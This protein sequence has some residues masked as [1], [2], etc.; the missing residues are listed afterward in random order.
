M[1]GKS[2][3]I[4]KVIPG[5]YAWVTL[6]LCIVLYD[7]VAVT[8]K[9]AET[10]SGAI[11]RSLAHPYKFPVAGVVWGA[12]SWHLFFNPQA[13]AAYKAVWSTHMKDYR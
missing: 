13:R 6:A 3:E 1:S 2:E 12:I 9:K 10:M 8:T 7:A 5:D 11:W 4:V